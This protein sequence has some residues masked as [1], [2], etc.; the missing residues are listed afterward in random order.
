[1]TNEKFP[2]TGACEDLHL[3]GEREKDE[4]DIATNQ[5]TVFRSSD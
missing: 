5:M 3:S 1:M 4:K 2:S